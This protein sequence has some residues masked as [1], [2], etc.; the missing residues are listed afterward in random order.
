MSDLWDPL[1]FFGL[2]HKMRNVTA[3]VSKV[4][5]I[6]PEFCGPPLGTVYKVLINSA[7]TAELKISSR[8]L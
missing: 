6:S 5:D 4:R 7:K 1:N 8:P 3:L 2:I